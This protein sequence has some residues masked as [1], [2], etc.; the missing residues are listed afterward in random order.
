MRRRGWCQSQKPQQPRTWL[1]EA[2][3]EMDVFSFCQINIWHSLK[4]GPH[5][6][7][8]GLLPVSSFLRLFLPFTY[9][10]TIIAPQD[11]WVCMLA[12]THKCTPFSLT[13]T[14]THTLENHCAPTRA[15]HGRQ[16]GE[17]MVCLELGWIEGLW[18]DGNHSGLP[19]LVTPQKHLH[20]QSI[21]V[22]VL[23]PTGVFSP[24]KGPCV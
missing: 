21:S 1:M 2:V 8:S 7:H 5:A 23:S 16:K 14:N 22:P 4:A 20:P 15:E 6:R 12:H 11:R 13:H 3:L 19:T 24:G 9:L 10:L 17:M 18:G